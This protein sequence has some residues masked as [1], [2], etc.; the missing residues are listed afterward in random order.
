MYC[1]IV[2]DKRIVVNGEP[3]LTPIIYFHFIL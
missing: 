2:G 1:C 3:Q